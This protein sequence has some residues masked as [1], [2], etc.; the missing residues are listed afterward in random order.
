MEELARDVEALMQREKLYTP[1]ISSAI[2][3]LREGSQLFFSLIPAGKGRF[4]FDNRKEFLEENGEEYDAL[5]HRATDRRRTGG[6]LPQKPEQVFSVAR[7]GAAIA[8]TAKFVMK[9]RTQTRLLDRA[10]RLSGDGRRIRSPSAVHSDAPRSD[11]K[12]RGFSR[13]ETLL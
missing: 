3:S 6:R 9:T 11:L 7:R 13:A 1:G 2:A 10:P 12:G 5:N 8:G 4:S